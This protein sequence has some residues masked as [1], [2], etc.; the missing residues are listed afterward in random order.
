MTNST[1]KWVRAEDGIIGGVCLSLARELQLDPW[2]VRVAWLMSVFVLGTGILAYVAC[3]IAL[4]RT[5]RLE[6][7]NESMILGVCLRLSK[8]QNMDIGLMRLLAI[9]TLFVSCGGAIFGYI[10]LHFFVPDSASNNE[11]PP[12]KSI[13]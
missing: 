8:R 1:A 12:R 2:L 5:D 4:P 10:L 6:A 7:A 11:I 13:I 9:V 3:V